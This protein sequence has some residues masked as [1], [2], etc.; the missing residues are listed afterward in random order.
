KQCWLYAPDELPRL[1]PFALGGGNPA[2]NCSQIDVEA[3]QAQFEAD[4][5]ASLSWRAELEA[6]DM[7]F[8]P[9]WWLHTFRHLGEFNAN[10]N[11]WWRPARPSWNVV[12]A[13]QELIDAASRAGLVKDAAAAP[14]LRALDA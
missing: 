11:F 3:P 12:A 4:W 14:T 2:H 9:A 7:L 10:L 13:R 5:S 8:I 1:H 6:G